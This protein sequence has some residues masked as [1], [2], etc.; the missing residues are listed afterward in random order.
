MEMAE[1]RIYT[2]RLLD[3]YDNANSERLHNLL[4]AISSTL[5][6]YDTIFD[7]D[8]LGQRDRNEGPFKY[9]YLLYYTTRQG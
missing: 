5:G 3:E 8:N 9:P 6:F 1:K 2:I 4:I 7:N